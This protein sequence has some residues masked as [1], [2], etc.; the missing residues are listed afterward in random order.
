MLTLLRVNLLAMKPAKK[1]NGLGNA[2]KDL[3]QFFKC[4]SWI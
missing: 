3:Y 4:N 1:L 2:T